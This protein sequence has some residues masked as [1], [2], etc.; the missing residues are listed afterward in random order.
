[1]TKPDRRV[2]KTETAIFQAFGDL[3]QE[4]KYPRITIQDIADRANVGR[5][6]LY[7]HFSTKDDLLVAFINRIFTSFYQHLAGRVLESDVR[8]HPVPVSEIFEHIKSNRRI[9]QGLFRSDMDDMLFVKMK[10]HW[11]NAV[12]AHLAD[13][14]SNCIKP[15]VPVDI[16]VNHI[17]SSLIELAKWWVETDSP[18]SPKQ[19]EA[20]FSVLILPS[21]YAAL[22]AT[23]P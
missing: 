18:Y 2:E 11:N 15:A 12:E 20:Y 17:T 13:S 7:S 14:I 23:D 6:T 1:M 19:M 5:T 4:K 9:I 10:K 22:P 16:L 8:T 21:V 3:L